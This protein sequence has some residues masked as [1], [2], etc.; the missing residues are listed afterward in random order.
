M[1]SVA[2]KLLSTSG[3]GAAPNPAPSQP[4]SATV[5]LVRITTVV[6]DGKRSRVVEVRVNAPGKTA[7][8]EVRLVKSNGKTLRRVQRVVPTNRLVQVPELKLDRIVK[9][10]RVTLT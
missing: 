1:T 8:I 6:D 7:S 4:A 5:A 10:V 2:A 9:T 3:T